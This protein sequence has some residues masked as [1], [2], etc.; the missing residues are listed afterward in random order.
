MITTLLA[1]TLTLM[2][3]NIRG[4][5][6]QDDWWDLGRSINVVKKVKPDVLCLQEV[7]W[8]TDR[9]YG[10][11]EP[12]AMGHILRPIWRYEFL[13]LTD[14]MNGEYGIAML[15]AE[16]PLKVEKIVLPKAA[17]KNEPR[18]LV[19]CEFEKYVVCTTHASLLPEEHEAAAKVY[20]SIPAKYPDKPVFITGDWNATPKEKLVQLMEREYVI[21]SDKTVMT[22][23][24]K[25]PDCTIDYIAVDK[26]HAPKVKTL[27]REVMN[28]PDE[29]VASDHLPTWV[30]VQIED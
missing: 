13:K 23:P 28:G 7:D 9:S 14:A 17:E 24:A 27:F 1:T 2:S 3:Y 30:K 8:A 5:L 16:K 6:G 12:Q 26:A 4:G 29:Q 25:K 21:L 11:R 20:T 15:F 19:V 22:A 10:C 18:G